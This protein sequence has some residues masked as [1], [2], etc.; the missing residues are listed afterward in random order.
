M[1]F[2]TSHRDNGQWGQPDSEN[3]G[4]ADAARLG[5]AAGYPSRYGTK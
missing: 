2:H 4:G 3:V 5:G 1:G